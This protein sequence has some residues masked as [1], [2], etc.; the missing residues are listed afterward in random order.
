MMLVGATRWD[1][2]AGEPARVRWRREEEL[3]VP[4]GARWRAIVKACRLEQ[5]LVSSVGS[6][7][8]LALDNE[9]LHAELRAR[10]TELETSRTRVLD[11]ALK[12]RQR[13]ERDL[14]DGAQQRFVS[15]ALTFAILDRNNK[16][17]GEQLVVTERA[18]EKHVT[19]IF[20]KLQLPPTTE[21]HRR[22]LAVLRYLRA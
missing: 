11:A 22:V 8:G 6:A 10:I 9:R 12:E 16:A 3:A 14:H 7:A 17:I 20:S 19:N 5:E 1:R 2:L 15:L 4:S 21:D 13:I 18:I